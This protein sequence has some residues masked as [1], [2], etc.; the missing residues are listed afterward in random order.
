[1]LLRIRS[2]FAP[3]HE[4]YEGVRP[5]NIYLLRLMFVLMF[6]A[7]GR[8]VWTYILS[9]EGAW[10]SDEAMAYSVLASFSVLAVLG[11]L[12]PLRMLPLVML[13]IAYKVMWLIMVAYPLWSAGELAG[14]ALES[15]TFSFSLVVLPIVA[16]PWKYAFDTYVRGRRQG[17]RKGRI[18]L[19]PVQTG[20]AT[21]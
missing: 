14:S 1:M 2:I 10:G 18:A 15:R 3:D 6:V 21:S 8:T 19:D 20:S 12:R 7:L 11:I 13:E 17:A 16:M 4:H 5:I 9:H